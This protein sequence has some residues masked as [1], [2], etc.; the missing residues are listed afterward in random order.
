LH[1]PFEFQPTKTGK[2]QLSLQEES[3]EIQ[4]SIA[5]SKSTQNL[6]QVIFLKQGMEDLFKCSKDLTLV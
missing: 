2:K 5:L 1:L 4:T 6:F 3:K